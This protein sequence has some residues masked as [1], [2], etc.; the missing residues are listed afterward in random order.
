M[1]KSGYFQ[2][3]RGEIVPQVLL[4]QAL[5]TVSKRECYRCHPR[6]H[7]IPPCGAALTFGT[8]LLT[9]SPSSGRTP[10]QGFE[11]YFSCALP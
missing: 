8:R 10:K 2:F 7:E 9:L 11:S 3:F 1:A 5:G 4:Y 6:K